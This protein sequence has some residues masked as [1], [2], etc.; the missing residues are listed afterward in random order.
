MISIR[1]G[2]GLGDALY[3]QSVAR[4]LVRE[5]K[6]V[7]ACCNWPEVFAPLGKAVMV[8]GFRR[9]GINVVAHYASRRGAPDTTQWEDVC[10][11][12]GI[13]TDTPLA[14]DW[15]K[16]VDVHEVVAAAA[17]LPVIVFGMP[18][19]PF[20]R[21][22]GYGVELLPKQA[23]MQSV[24]Y[25]LAKRAFVVQVGLGAPT[26]ALDG[27]SLNLVNRIG[28]TQMIDLVAAA[29]AVVGQPS[30]MVPLAESLEKPG[31]IVWA[32]AGRHSRHEPVRQITPRK[33][34]HRKDL[35]NSIW[36]D[37]HP[38]TIAIAANALC[39]SIE[40]RQAA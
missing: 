30:F 16:P 20:A 2:S 1:G 14:L 5:G 12:A 10:L 21:R 9:D 32:R 7:E 15:P 3:V 22:D 13:P 26:F 37:E 18:R 17:G 8:T 25:E 36:D 29:D 34:I 6:R 31:L 33:V 38:P 11:T 23:A 40:R 24:L 4:H 19:P 27:F 28:V 35:L 39:G